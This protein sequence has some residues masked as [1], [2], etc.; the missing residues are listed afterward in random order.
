[1]EPPT[2]ISPLT[3]AS[4]VTFRVW[5][6]TS[7]MDAEDV[8]F[9]DPTVAVPETSMLENLEFLGAKTPI[10][11]RFPITVVF[12]VTLSSPSVEFVAVM[13]P[14]TAEPATTTLLKEAS[15]P[16]A[17]KAPST[18]KSPPTSTS[19]STINL[20]IVV[21]ALIEAV[22]ADRESTV[23]LP[24]TLIFRKVVSS[25]SI[26]PATFRPPPILASLSTVSA[27]LIIPDEADKVSMV[28]VPNTLMSWNTVTASSIE[29]PTAMSPPISASLFTVK[30][31]IVAAPLIT[32]EDV[33]N[34]SMVAL[35]RTLIFWKV[36]SSKSMEPATLKLPPISASAVIVMVSS[37][38]APLIVAEEA[39]KESTVAVPA[40]LMSW[41]TVVA[42]SVEP[43]TLR[44]PPM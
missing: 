20:C 1:M 21:A 28:A 29:P 4:S 2:F 42:R 43:A 33:V 37:V 41:K 3:S 16:A 8:A 5:T 26:E 6:V 13:I 32:A 35:P 10:T 25:S 19:A 15:F 12:P 44:F 27:P 39:D 34:E 11:S 23:A 22:D 30:V 40:T 14:T 9:R 31:S 18:F 36:V 38:A 24:R 7:P 17:A